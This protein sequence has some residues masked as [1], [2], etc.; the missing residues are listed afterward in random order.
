MEDSSWAIRYII[1]DTRNWWPGK[2]VLV[3]PEWIERVDWSDSKVHVGVTR[4]ADREESRVRSAG[5][6]FARLRGAVA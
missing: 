4:E 5:P 6:R 1:V 3:S 2:K